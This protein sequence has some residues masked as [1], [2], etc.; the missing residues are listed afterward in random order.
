[1]PD[2]DGLANRIRPQPGP[3]YRGGDWLSPTVVVG[4][5]RVADAAVVLLAASAAWITRFYDD[6]TKEL[7]IEAYASVLAV[8]LTIHIQQ[9]AGLYSFSQLTNLFG[10]VGRLLLAW[11]AVMLS[12]LALGF[13][14]KMN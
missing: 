3:R 14:T 6:P 12:L 10:Q 11:A 8:L 9:A 1:M 7:G 13:V 2:F 4:L 5:L